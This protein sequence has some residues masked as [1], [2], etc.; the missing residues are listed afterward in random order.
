MIPK[1]VAAAIAKLE[2]LNI[3]NVPQ[4]DVSSLNPNRLKFL[5]QMAKRSSNQ[6]LQRLHKERRYPILTAFVYQIYEEVTDETIDL[7]IYCLADTYARARRELDEFRRNAAKA[8]NEKIR[9][10][11]EL[12]SVVVDTNVSDAQG[13]SLDLQAHFT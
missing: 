1:A 6:A 7:Y 12:G 9:L 2:F 10:F 13:K 11:R 5:A 3:Q 4:W 8:I